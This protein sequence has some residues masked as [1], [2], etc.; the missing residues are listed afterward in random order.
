MSLPSCGAPAVAVFRVWL[1]RCSSSAPYHC[2]MAALK[3]MGSSSAFS[4]VHKGSHAARLLCS[5]SCPWGLGL[6]RLMPAPAA[7]DWWLAPRLLSD[8][9]ESLSR[10]GHIGHGLRVSWGPRTGGH[11][12][13]G[14]FRSSTCAVC[15]PLI[16]SHG[17][18][19][20]KE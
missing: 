8:A 11:R 3:N 15:W 17:S 12:K 18:S 20:K 13:L 10:H 6:A 4:T 7:S 5:H 16:S 19:L 1:L 14:N 9:L 2:H